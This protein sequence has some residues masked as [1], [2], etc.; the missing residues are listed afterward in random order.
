MPSKKP[1]WQFT[2]EQ[3]EQS[4]WKNRA[5]FAEWVT[6]WNQDEA[7]RVRKTNAARSSKRYKAAKA[8]AIDWYMAHLRL[9]PGE[10]AK[11]IRKKLPMRQKPAVK[12]I[13]EWLADLAPP[14]RR[15]RGRPKK[16]K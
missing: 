13:T 6:R 11:E 12:T 16:K 8:F 9:K 15:G 3:D 10:A 7:Q 4:R 2:P 14:E 1:A 5:L